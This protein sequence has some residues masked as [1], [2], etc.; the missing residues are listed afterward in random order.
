[1]L[2]A[3]RNIV[4]AVWCALIAGLF[5]FIALLRFRG[6]ELAGMEIHGYGM[7]GWWSV[8]PPAL[9]AVSALIALLWVPAPSLVAILSLILGALTLMNIVA[10]S[11]AEA[12]F[13]AYL[14]VGS[15]F[16][17]VGLFSSLLIYLDRI[18]V[19][20]QKRK[21]DEKNMAKTIAEEF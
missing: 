6:L 19:R 2:N 15:F 11:G 8:G 10:I 14:T 18:A 9:I 13:G 20:S 7:L 5:G 12:E 16:A 4:T 17:A 1:M 3:I 21:R